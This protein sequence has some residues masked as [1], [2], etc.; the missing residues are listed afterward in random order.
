MNSV[1]RVVRR[2]IG[3]PK[4]KH[5][6]SRTS[7]SAYELYI[8]LLD[9]AKRAENIQH[10]G[11]NVQTLDPKAPN[12]HW[13]ADIWSVI[14]GRAR[15]LSLALTGDELE[16]IAQMFW[17]LSRVERLCIDLHQEFTHWD[18]SKSD[19]LAKL[20]NLT[21]ANLVNFDLRVDS[22]P[23]S[24]AFRTVF[25]QLGVSFVWFSLNHNSTILEISAH[26]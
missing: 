6:F 23:Y 3:R 26:D 15:S 8:M 5:P 22:S 17:D 18:D 12:I 19:R 2:V 7:K 16:A 24:S 10:V 25:Q 14:S 20:F 21:S 11:F 13:A 1:S 9:T 4:G